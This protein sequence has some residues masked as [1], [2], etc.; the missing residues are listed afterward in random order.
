M[1]LKDVNA[2]ERFSVHVWQNF[3]DGHDQPSASNDRDHVLSEELLSILE[4]WNFR[5]VTVMSRRFR[6]PGRP[7]ETWLYNPVIRR[8]RRLAPARRADAPVGQDISPD[9]GAFFAG[10]PAAFDWRL[11]GASEALAFADRRAV[12]DGT[13]QL[14]RQPDG[15]FVRTDSEKARFA[16]QQAGFEASPLRPLDSEVI[17]VNRPVW[18]V[19][20]SSREVRY[21]FPKIVMWFDRE[22]WQGIFVVKYDRTGQAGSVYVPVLERF[23]QVDGV[24]RSY[25]ASPFALMEDLQ[26][27]HTTTV[28]PA[29]SK[30][31]RRGINVP[32]TL[33]ELNIVTSLGH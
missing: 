33:F 20:G 26:T 23:F 31:A 32:H 11:I 29:P 9:D 14:R 17:L 10:N 25:A 27:K 6:D 4:P 3:W 7:D 5:G 22:T 8:I 19:E 15:S 30:P 28:Y 13:H 12:I 24:W 2:R 21:L 16:Y 1:T 18:V